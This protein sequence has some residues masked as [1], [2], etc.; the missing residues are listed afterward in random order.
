[1]TPSQEIQEGRLMAEEMWK[2]I[3]RRLPNAKCYQILGNHDLRPLKRVTEKFP[4]IASL[5]D[6]SHLWNFPGVITH[7][8]TRTPLIIEGIDF[9]HGHRSKLGDHAKYTIR[10]TVCGHTHRGGVDFIPLSDGKIIFELNAG[11]LA[12]PEHEALK[13]T[14]NKLSK[15]THGVGWIDEYGPRFIPL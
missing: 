4:E 9:T 11:Y 7:H 14:P 6:M 12:D 13:Y 15:W 2:S 3:Q 5:I 1:M 10:S 8:D